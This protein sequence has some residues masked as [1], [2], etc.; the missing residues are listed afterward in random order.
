[1]AS[2]N[3]GGR[4]ASRSGGGGGKKS[5]S[6]RNAA[7]ER[8]NLITVCRFSVKTL[9]DRSC[10]ETIDDSS[11]EFNNFAA[12]LEQILS[13]RLKGVPEGE[14][15][16]QEIENLFEK[17]M[18]ENFANLA[19]EIDFQEVQEAQR[20]PKKLDPRKHTLRDFPKLQMA[21]SSPNTSSRYSMLV[22]SPATELHGSM[23]LT[24]WGGLYQL[25][26][27]F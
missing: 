20:V 25:S 17:K 1:M 7:V 26:D 24:Y 18:K 9:I 14:E 6:A 3:L 12:I 21:G 15:E 11:P 22:I 23:E 5:L 27:L 10:F 8:R 4:S 2:R 19:E 16:E 13:H